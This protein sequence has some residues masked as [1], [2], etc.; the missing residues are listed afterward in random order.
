MITLR[1]DLRV[2]KTVLKKQKT[3]SIHKFTCW[4]TYITIRQSHANSTK[5]LSFLVIKDISVEFKKQIK[6]NSQKSFE[7]KHKIIL[8]EKSTN[9][10]IWIEV[11]TCLHKNCYE[12]V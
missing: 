10:N 5:Y 8:E 6:R 12:N 11:Y 2:I 4:S 7:I 1:N 3:K 9:D